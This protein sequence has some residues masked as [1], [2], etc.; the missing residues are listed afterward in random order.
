MITCLLVVSIPSRD[1]TFFT[2]DLNNNNDHDDD[3]DD[4]DDDDDYL[5]TFSIPVS[6]L[7]S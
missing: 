3:D 1:V 2:T 6:L 7:V 5:G 4:N